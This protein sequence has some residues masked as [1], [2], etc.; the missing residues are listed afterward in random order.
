[1]ASELDF[2]RRLQHEFPAAPP[3][4]TGIGDDGSVIDISGDERQVVVADM[5]LDGVH[6]DL[7][8]TDPALIGRKALAVNLSDLAAMGC[9][10]VSAYVCL[11]LP[12]GLP[13][14]FTTQLYHGLKSLAK[15]F[16]CTIAG[17]DTNS[18]RGP[19]AISVTVT[20]VPFG[21]RIPLRCDAA[22]GD[23]ICVTGHLGGSLP[24]GRHLSFTP[25]LAMAERLLQVCDVHAM[26]DISDGVSLDLARMMEASGRSAVLHEDNIP[27][28][29]DVDAQLPWEQ[30]IHHA[31]HDGEDFELLVTLPRLPDGLPDDVVLI[32]IGTVTAAGTGILLQRSDGSSRPLQPHGWQHDV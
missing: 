15:Q 20:G 7:T 30:R 25:Q 2:L 26:M 32:P 8:E 22:V 19:F 18:W 17:G 4:L 13:A 11:A 14:A 5:L 9:R 28:H 10:P 12:H 23:V 24:S 31:L 6:F 16:H 1:M 21:D 3:V 29:G 27:I